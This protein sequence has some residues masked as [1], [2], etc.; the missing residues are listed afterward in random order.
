MGNPPSPPPPLKWAQIR[1][2]TKTQGGDGPNE[3]GRIILMFTGKSRRL[4]ERGREREGGREGE[5][6]GKREMGSVCFCTEAWTNS[7]HRFCLL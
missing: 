1:R 7:P 5:R 6:E 4:G 3:A 2:V